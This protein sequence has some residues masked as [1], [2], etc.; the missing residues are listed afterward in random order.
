MFSLI[1]KILKYLNDTIYFVHG[2]G[3]LK[4]CLTLQ[5]ERRKV[6]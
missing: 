1:W 3:N 4:K 5:P 2:L 6:P